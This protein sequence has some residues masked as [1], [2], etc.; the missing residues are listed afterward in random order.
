[1][2][3]SES[4]SKIAPALLKAQKAITFAVKDSKN[5]HFKSTYAD[6]GSVIDACK[7]ALNDAGIAFMQMPAP[8][9]GG[10]IALTTRLVHESGEWIESTAT[11]PLPKNDPQGYGS[12]N[13][14]LRRYSLAAAVGLYQDDDD[15]NAATKKAPI[16]EAGSLRHAV[17][18]GI[19]DNLPDDWKVYL[20]D[21]AAECAEMVRTG[22][23]TR[24]AQRIA[25]DKLDDEQ[26]TYLANKMDSKTRSAIKA[27]Q[28]EIRAA[29]SQKAAA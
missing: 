16:T 13:T 23:A 2:N 8:S 28:A 27:A 14:Y 6:L 24:A 11:C 19:G 21:L 3:T 29:F 15:G 10:T 1:M 9:D 7:P 5:P 4:I 12:A 18:D 22:N 26:G 20:T 25:V 17:R